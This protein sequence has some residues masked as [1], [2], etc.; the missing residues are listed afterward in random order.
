MAKIATEEMCGL[1]PTNNAKML[2]DAAQTPLDTSATNPR[3]FRDE[4]MDAA[5][6][7][8]MNRHPKLFIMQ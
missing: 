6:R 5:L 8:I 1:L 2:R 7:M 4:A 3:Y